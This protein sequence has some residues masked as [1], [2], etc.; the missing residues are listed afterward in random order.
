MKEFNELRDFLKDTYGNGDVS[1]IWKAEKV[2]PETAHKSVEL[3]Q[4]QTYIVFLIQK[5]ESEEVKTFLKNEY[6]YLKEEIFFYRLKTDIYCA[7]A[8]VSDGHCTTRK[9]TKDEIKIYNKW[10]DFLTNESIETMDKLV[11]TYKEINGYC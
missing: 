8:K 4:Q 3:L 1:Q 6:E 9:L 2:Y 10:I 5:A 7:V 11:D